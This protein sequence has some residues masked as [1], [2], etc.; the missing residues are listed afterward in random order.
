[1]FH[2]EDHYWATI[3]AWLKRAI[4]KEPKV[5]KD[6]ECLI[7]FVKKE[8]TV[9]TKEQ[10]NIEKG[11]AAKSFFGRLLSVAKQANAPRRP[12]K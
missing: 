3:I 1:M 7:K 6:D 12:A 9:K 2:R 10:Q 4:V 11:K 5:V 8:V